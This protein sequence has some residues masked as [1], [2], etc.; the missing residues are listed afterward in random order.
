MIGISIL[1]PFRMPYFILSCIKWIQLSPFDK[2]ALT[3]NN[4]LV[5]SMDDQSG[6]LILGIHLDGTRLVGRFRVL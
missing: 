3:E 6:Y 1:G 2:N 5:Q 4:R